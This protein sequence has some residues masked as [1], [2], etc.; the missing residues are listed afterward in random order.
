M[1][2][3]RA[4]SHVPRAVRPATAAHGASPQTRRWQ[5]PISCPFPPARRA[6]VSLL[7]VQSNCFSCVFA[8]GGNGVIG[9]RAVHAGV[10]FQGEK[11][12]RGRLPAATHDMQKSWWVLRI[13]V[14]L[15][16]G[17]VIIAIIGVSSRSSPPPPPHPPPN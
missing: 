11:S 10:N 12:P 16:F 1:G 9:R 4:R 13:C 14:R 15:G 2:S 7:I 8:R 5:H 3:L 17:G 6:N